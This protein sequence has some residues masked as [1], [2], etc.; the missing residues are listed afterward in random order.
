[1]EH[2][3][4]RQEET[5]FAVTQLDF[6]LAVRGKQFLKVDHALQRRRRALD[7]GVVDHDF[8]EYLCGRP[9]C[10]QMAYKNKAFEK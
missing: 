3:V 4:E 8:A 7:I 1:M 6:G 5:N 9:R 2:H 10:V